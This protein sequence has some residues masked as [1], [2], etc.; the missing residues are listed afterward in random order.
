M[1]WQPIKSAPEGERVLV[2][3]RRGN[4]L[5]ARS[6][7]LRWYDDAERLLDSPRWWMP[8]PEAPAEPRTVGGKVPVRASRRLTTP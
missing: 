7:A 4:V 3:A 6:V 5:I 8:L 1:P 2:C